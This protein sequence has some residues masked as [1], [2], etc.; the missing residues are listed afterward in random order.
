VV[1]VVQVELMQ[2]LAEGAEI[3]DKMDLLAQ[4]EILMAA[5]VALVV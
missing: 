2:V 1:Q 5:M 4:M 3:W